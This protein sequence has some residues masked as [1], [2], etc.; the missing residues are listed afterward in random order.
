MIRRR[1]LKKPNLASLAL[2][3]AG[4]LLL[5]WTARLW[6]GYGQAV[7]SAQPTL[8][9][10]AANLSSRGD[11]NRTAATP[12]VTATPS[13]GK[14]FKG[15]VSWLTGFSTD[16]AQGMSVVW[17][18]FTQDEGQ[19]RPVP[20]QEGNGPAD[21]CVIPPEIQVE[22]D[23]IAPNSTPAPLPQEGV[24]VLIYHTHTT[25]AYEK[26]A[27]DNYTESSQWRTEN[28]DYNIVRV[29]EELTRQL[30]QRG[31]TVAHDTTNHEPPKLGTAYSRSLK[32]VEDYLKEYPN[33]SVIIDLHRDAYIEGAS[34][35]QTVTVDG[36]EVARILA[37]IG[38]GEGATGNGF[39]VKPNWKENYKLAQRVTDNL[40]AVQ[41]GLAKDIMVRTGRYNQHVSTNAILIEMG[42]N[43]NSLQQ[44]LAS[45]PYLADAIQKAIQ[46]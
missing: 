40:Q 15:F 32:T 26:Q 30:E 24:Q 5:G 28:N 37:V 38:T 8:T 36:K 29:G 17:P 41:P 7:K 4:L 42:N 23:Q 12:D 22:I 19:T 33:L 27:G 2:V 20:A 34:E 10:T 3:L 9:P 25:E 6:N 35:P 43:K 16:P 46:G 44:V 1:P 18:G 31:L 21:P 14:S 13:S 11:A 45:V 39:S